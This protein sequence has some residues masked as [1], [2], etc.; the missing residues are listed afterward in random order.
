LDWFSEHRDEFGDLYEGLLQENADEK[1]SGA[2][3]YFTPRPL[4]DCMVSLLK[5]QPGELIQDPAAGTGGFL[6]AG[7][8]YI[9]Q[10]HDPFEWTEAQQSFQQ[11]QAFYGMELVQDAHRLLLMK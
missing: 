3:Q 2:G 8:R 6:I 9:R 1:K 7:D 4:I 11:H 10:Y 5:P